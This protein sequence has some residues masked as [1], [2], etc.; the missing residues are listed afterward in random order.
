M[1]TKLEQIGVK[2]VNQLPKSVVRNVALE[3]IWRPRS[4]IARFGTRWRLGC[5]IVIMAVAATEEMQRV[6]GK[7][8]ESKSDHRVAGHRRTKG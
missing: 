8:A 2:A 3:F 7:S 5:S 1:E 6:I 4:A